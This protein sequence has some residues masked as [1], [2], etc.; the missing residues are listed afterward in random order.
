MV[1]LIVIFY[2]LTISSN[3]L[4]LDFDGTEPMHNLPFKAERKR[5]LC[6]VIHCNSNQCVTFVL[7]IMLYVFN[8]SPNGL[9]LDYGETDPI[10]ARPAL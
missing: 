3:D 7:I 1:V 5:V 2:I 4:C 8:I 9:C 10:H 6:N